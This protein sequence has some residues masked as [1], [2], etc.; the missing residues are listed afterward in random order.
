M[1]LQVKEDQCHRTGG[2]GCLRRF[3]TI[4]GARSSHIAKVVLAQHLLQHLAE[5]PQ[6]TVSAILGKRGRRSIERNFLKNIIHTPRESEEVEQ[7]LMD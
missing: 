7:L 1:Q 3:I 5:F 4:F 2:G 6:L